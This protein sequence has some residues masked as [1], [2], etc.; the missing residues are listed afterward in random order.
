MRGLITRRSAG[1]TP[2]GYTVLWGMCRPRRPCPP[3]S[4]SWLRIGRV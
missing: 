2:P 3:G 4:T 1:Y